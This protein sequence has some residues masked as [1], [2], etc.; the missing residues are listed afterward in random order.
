[1]TVTGEVERVE[2]A[3]PHVRIS[4]RSDGGM[5]YDV[6]WLN[7]QLLSLAG[8]QR[9][10]LN[11]GDR[12]VITAGRRAEDGTRVPMLLSEIRRPADGWQWSQPPQ[13]C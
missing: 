10:T 2:W 3:N 9:G 11:V 8:I 13:G 7:Q 5:T 4:I 12:V 1:L 6:V